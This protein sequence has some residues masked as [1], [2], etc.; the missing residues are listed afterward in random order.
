MKRVPK[1]ANT[2]Q[3]CR[4]GQDTKTRA[5]CRPIQGSIMR[6]RLSQAIFSS[7]TFL[8]LAELYGVL[9]A[10]PVNAARV[11]AWGAI[12]ICVYIALARIVGWDPGRSKLASSASPWLRYLEHYEMRSGNATLGMT[13]IVIVAA[14]LLDPANFVSAVVSATLSAWVYFVVR[15][16]N[17][18]FKLSEA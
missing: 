5:N 13:L 4:A 15:L 3:F 11:L 2:S 17:G 18:G 6:A 7:T 14:K 12:G 9:Y 16:Y 8:A 10:Q 1:L